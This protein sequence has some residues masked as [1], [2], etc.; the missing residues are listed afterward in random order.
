MSITFFFLMM[1]SIND[2]QTLLSKD[3]GPIEELPNFLLL[4]AFAITYI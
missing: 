4:S 1:P 3:L 2:F